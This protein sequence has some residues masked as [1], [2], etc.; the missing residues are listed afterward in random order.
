MAELSD[1]ADNPA[2]VIN[3]KTWGAFK[4]AAYSASYPADPFEGLPV[5]FNNTLP[6]YADATT[7]ATWAVVGD[8]ENG[9]LANFPNGEEIQFKFDELSLKKQDLIEV[10]GREFVAL[11]VIAPNH[12]VNV[13][14]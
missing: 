11:G 1:Q 14:K 7:G 10:L 9:A 2:V 8:F 5:V 12:F 6:A 4:A 3:R 13:K